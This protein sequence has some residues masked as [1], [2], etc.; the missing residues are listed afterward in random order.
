A[1]CAHPPPRLR[2]NLNLNRNPNPSPPRLP[3]QRAAA[4]GPRSR[5][6]VPSWIFGVESA[7]SRFR[8]G[9]RGPVPQCIHPPIHQSNSHLAHPRPSVIKRVDPNP[10]EPIRTNI[11][12]RPSDRLAKCHGLSRDMSRVGL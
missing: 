9:V 2:P 7:K 5:P 6:E 8:I 12:F 4:A 11:F 3:R 10:S 1:P